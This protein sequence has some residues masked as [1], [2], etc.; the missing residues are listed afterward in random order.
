M[1]AADEVWRLQRGDGPE[2]RFFQQFADQAHYRRKGGTRQGIYVCTASGK[3]LGSMNSNNAEAVAKMLTGA[4]SKWKSL[5]DS[6]RRIPERANFK[7]AH[8]WEDSFPNDGLVLLS[9]N[10]D[11]PLD[12]NP[13]SRTGDR[14]NRDHVWFSRDEARTWL[15]ADPRV[16]RTHNVPDIIVQRLARFHL[17]DN[18]GGQTLPFAASEVPGSTIQTEVVKREGTTVR[19][20]ISGSTKA[21]T[22]DEWLMGKNIWTPRRQY[23]HGVRQR[24]LG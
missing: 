24:L 22:T 7:P 9:A 8:R 16:G 13:G 19:L 1:P 18:V 5:A 4:L 12:G 2:S 6:D 14:W 15:P 17:V 23:P 10:R 20:R 3:L 11:L 21:E